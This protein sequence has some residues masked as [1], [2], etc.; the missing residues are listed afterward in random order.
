M[1]NLLVHYAVGRAAGLPLARPED[2]LVLVAGNLL[3]DVAFKA[4]YYL[5]GASSSFA[6]P[7]HAPL[8]LPVFA[9]LAALAFEPSYRARAFAWLLAGAAM[10]VL[11]DAGKDYAGGGVIWW[12]FPF[13]L[14]RWQWGLYDRIPWAWTITVAVAVIALV[15]AIERLVRRPA[16]APQR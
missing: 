8:M 15:E 1:A 2:R 10:H 4:M 12:A 13:S 6:E 9:L 3:P 14:D 16:P 5:G 11:L 7:T